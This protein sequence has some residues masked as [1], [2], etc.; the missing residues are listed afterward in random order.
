MTQIIDLLIPVVIGIAFTLVGCLK[1]YGL[2]K[3]IVGGHDKPFVTQL[4]GT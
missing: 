3:G 4:C 1:L 2:R